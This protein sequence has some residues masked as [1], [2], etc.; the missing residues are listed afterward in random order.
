MASQTHPNHT[1]PAQG[2]STGAAR[3]GRSTR[4]D[5][6]AL[7]AAEAAVAPV[8]QIGDVIL[9]LYE[10]TDLLGEGGM[11]QVYKVRHRAWDLDLAVKTPRTEV[12]G[13]AEGAANFV[14]EAQTWV[15]LGLHPHT[16][17]CYY[18]RTLGGIP[19]LFAEYVNDGSLADW[20]H[21]KKLYA[22]SME[23]IYARILDIAIQFAWGL[24]HAHE[25]GVVHMDVKPANVM[26]TA[27][28][29]AKVTDFGLAKA[30][31]GAS[32]HA[33]AGT[34]GASILV[35]TGGMTPAYC[36]PEQAAGLPLSRKTD[37][38]SWGL[39][40]LEMFAGEV[41]WLAGQ[42]ASEALE[43]YV[44]ANF[45]A[46]AP[47]MP[48]AL[49][50]LLRRCFSADPAARP[51]DMKEIEEVLRAV[52][53][54]LCRRP[55]ARAQ[56]SPA[57]LTAESLNNR[58]L[59]YLDLGMESDATEAW[60]A[61][62]QADPQHIE[63]LYNQG[64]CLWRRGELIDEEVRR[65]LDAARRSHRG[66]WLNEYLLAL[67]HLERGDSEQAIALL[68]EVARGDVSIVDDRIVTMLRSGAI[69]AARRLRVLAPRDDLG[70]E[71]ADDS[72]PVHHLALSDDARW[73]L[74]GT[75]RGP[76]QFWDTASGQRV[77]TFAS[78]S[79]AFEY[80][81]LSPDGNTALVASDD[82]TL[83][84]LDTRTG[85][86]LRTFEPLDENDVLMSIGFGA[87]ARLA[88]SGGL[89][90]V[91]VW[92]AATGKCLRR[93]I[94]HTDLVCAVAVSPDGRWALSASSLK[95]KT[96]RLWDVATGQCV[97]N[98]K[99]HEDSASAVC[100]SADSR[101]ALSASSD[102]TVRMWD[103]ETGQSVR[104]FR[105]R[106][107]AIG[108][109][110]IGRDGRWILSGG[111]TVRLWD[112]VSGRCVRTLAEY[113]TYG[114]RAAI[115]ADGRH[116][117]LAT[118]QGVAEF[119]ELPAGDPFVAP[120]HVSRVR[121]VEAISETEE[122]ARELLGEAQ[123]A[124]ARSKFGRALE[125]A[126]QIRSLPGHERARGA[127]D[128]W[129][130]LSLRCARSSLRGAWS[131]PALGDAMVNSVAVS[132]D[133]RYALCGTGG[134]EYALQ[135]W[136]LASGECVRTIASEQGEVYCVCLSADGGVGLSG[137]YMNA[138]IRVW[139]LETGKCTGV[140]EGHSEPPRSLSVSADGLV[141]LSGSWDKTVRLWNVR[142]ATCVHAFEGHTAE[143]DAV[144]LSQDGFCLLSGSKD[145]TMR[146]WDIAT[147][148]CVRTFEVPYSAIL[149][150]AIGPYGRW[151]IT[152]LGDKTLRMWDL[153]TGKCLRVFEGHALWALGVSV[154]ADGR[155]V[156]SAS[157][158]RTLKLWNVATGEC[159]YTFEGH[160]WAVKTV[161]LSA[162]GRW[163]LAGGQDK[164][165]KR[166]ELDWDLEAREP[167]TWDDAAEPFLRTFI[168][169]Y[170]RRSLAGQRKFEWTEQDFDGLI[171]MLACAGYGYL[172]PDGVRKQ[173][174]K[175][176]ASPP[177]AALEARSS[178]SGGI[179]ASLRKLFGR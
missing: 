137:G 104:V 27:S 40:T 176:G 63:S 169:T 80:V 157:Q 172:R 65:R 48:P 179:M 57:T 38:W 91:Y 89:A 173:L 118:E 144:A 4:L 26:M 45:E 163:A 62:L 150:I 133:A 117:L 64:L 140:M 85:R 129:R 55:Y 92:D 58:A 112:A 170:Q 6:T 24:H 94:G 127:L 103:V 41:T 43:G 162:D 67:I 8:W 70:R 155:F 78:E 99:G 147:R 131:A 105:G 100:F 3:A 15:N 22:G 101:F 146:K 30:R 120:Y 21:T 83:Q 44:E 88:V 95:D 42:A 142:D 76:L 72:D 29:V 73:A 11:G 39:S 143:I 54:E 36:S 37:V 86:A 81:R 7:T 149:A 34:A 84:L 171:H 113:K 66:V 46:P 178:G 59:S 159:L 151:A 156:L 69:P 167:A 130:Q 136:D 82:K 74:L 14:R 98:L 128:L 122:R 47:R 164:G 87:E 71:F 68:G 18:V 168:V 75:G 119:W 79:A 123:R 28:G 33:A 115:S 31:A 148:A 109:V 110:G 154:S 2:H 56:P 174:K 107:E 5:H 134:P 121:Q 35:S 90:D 77:R 52:Y 93:L 49:V 102:S 53:A 12:F 132:A 60:S 161:A 16:V 160:E 25:Q 1:Q 19:R 50:L 152:A 108:T 138:A 23:Q 13:A 106:E 97:W 61:A 177:R 96:V 153:S 124:L 139:D 158:D 165:L 116:A 141:A 135:L 166:W 20:I 10:V 126:E 51:R 145:R 17:S 125:C 32:Q 175:M 9:D 111:K 114:V